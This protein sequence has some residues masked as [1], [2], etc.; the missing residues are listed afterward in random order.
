MEEEE[1][2]EFILQYCRRALVLLWKYIAVEGLAFSL[3]FLIRLLIHLLCIFIILYSNPTH[4]WKGVQ[5][6]LALPGVLFHHET[7]TYDW[8]HEDL[9][10][11]VTYIP[12]SMDLEDVSTMLSHLIPFSLLQEFL[13]YSPFHPCFTTSLYLLSISCEKSSNGPKPTQ[14]KQEQFPMPPRHS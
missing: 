5:S 11:W 1:P 7:P 4:S 8:F 10:P 3:T 9:I 6:K 13:E 2:R 14:N 12:V